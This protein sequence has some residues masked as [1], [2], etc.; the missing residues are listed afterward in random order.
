MTPF[1][2][3]AQPKSKKCL[4]SI[5]SN[6]NLLSALFQIWCLEKC[7]QEISPAGKSP[8]ENCPLENYPRK[9]APQENCPSEKLHPGKLFY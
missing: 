9:Y 2:G 6:K 3:S 8:R 5:L 1:H 7:P 4:F